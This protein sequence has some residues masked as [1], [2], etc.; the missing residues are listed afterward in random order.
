[1]LSKDT[2]LTFKRSTDVTPV[3]ATGLLQVPQME[4]ERDQIEVTDLSDS[5]KTYINGLKDAGD[6]SMQFIYDNSSADSV[7]RAFRTASD[8]DTALDFVLTLPDT[9]AFSFSGVPSVTIDEI[10]V[11]DKI[12]FTA[13][14]ALSTD[15]TIS[16]PSY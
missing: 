8:A 9:T 12:T 10:G 1:M 14:I 16:D 5:R 6:L 2:T 15:I 7:Y 11:N 4:G 3:L 13:K